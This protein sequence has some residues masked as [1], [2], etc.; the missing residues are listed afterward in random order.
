MSPNAFLLTLDL[1]GTFV[2]ALNGALTAIKVARL[3]IVGVLT[4]AIITGVGGGIMRDVLIGT[5][6]PAAFRLWY[7][8]AVAGLGG[9]L[10]AAVGPR[11][12]RLRVPIL[13]LDAAGLSLY[14]VVGSGKALDASLGILPAV[15]LGVMTA[16]GGGT[17]RDLMTQ[18]VPSVLHSELYA[19]PA[20]L[21][22]VIVVAGYR[23]GLPELPTAIV[24]ACA[25]F[26]LRGFGLKYRLNM[27]SIPA[28]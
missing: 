17:I 9:V 16:V 24:G 14:A 19:L 22:A 2:F 13:V 3:D 23:M 27:P 12:N 25:C 5:V 4:L 26:A 10:V 7:Y 15:L 11:L 18:Q 20:L 28:S 6:P 21:A 1:I 8:L